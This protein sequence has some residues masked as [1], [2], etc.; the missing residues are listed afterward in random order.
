MQN[1]KNELRE[2]KATNATIDHD[3]AIQELLQDIHLQMERDAETRARRV[4]R[5]IACM[6]VR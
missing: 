2:V 1:V 6:A 4:A 3:L 5:Q